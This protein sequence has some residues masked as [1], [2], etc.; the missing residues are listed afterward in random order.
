MAETTNKKHF[1]AAFTTKESVACD[2]CQGLGLVCVL[3][4]LYLV[5]FLNLSRIIPCLAALY[6]GVKYSDV[7]VY[8]KI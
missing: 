3:R 6:T 1:D 2:S 7:H 5:F 8:Q 4:I